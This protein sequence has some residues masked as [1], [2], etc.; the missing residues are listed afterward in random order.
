MKKFLKFGGIGCGTL[1]GFFIILAIL[2]AVFGWGESMQD[3]GPTVDNSTP[4]TGSSASQNAPPPNRALTPTPQFT[5]TSAPTP[6]PKPVEVTAG[7]L[8]QAYEDNEV[9]A[10]ATYEK[11]TALITGTVAS[12]TE[13][14]S[15]YDVKLETDPFLSFV[16]VVCKVDKSHQAMILPLKRGQTIT[17]LGL[18]KGVSLVDIVIENCTVAVFPPEPPEASNA[19]VAPASAE[20]TPP[21]ADP[22]P[23]PTPAHTSTPYPTPTQAPTATPDPIQSATL[24][25]GT[26]EVGVDLEP[27]IYAGIAGPGLLSSCY[28]ERLKGVS[29]NFEDIVANDIP[30]GQ[31]YVKVLPSDAFLKVGCS[32]LPLEWWPAPETHLSEIDAGTY[33]VGRDISPGTY[34][35]D[36]G[37]DVLSS[38][39]WARLSGLSGSFDDLITNDNAVGQFFVNVAPTDTALTVGCPMTFRGN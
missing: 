15:K 14:G 30:V 3:D 19:A 32:I 38:C 35:G 24:G 4:P 13:A 29:G 23:V 20:V 27:G 1:I 9:A 26:Y 18:I 22:T 31:F 6:T 39:Y 8:Y 12:V 25:P 5:P 17:V 34:Q 37:A 11:K 33:I 28:W 21:P 10:K 36:G 7:N 16:N 2:S